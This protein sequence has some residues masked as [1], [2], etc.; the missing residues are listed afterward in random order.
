[1]AAVEAPA[2]YSRAHAVRTRVQAGLQVR[3]V[4]EGVSESEAMEDFC[5]CLKVAFTPCTSRFRVVCFGRTHRIKLSWGC[6]VFL[7]FAFADFE[8]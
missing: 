1:M 8:C 7:A 2:K 6:I 4:S 5:R 3:A